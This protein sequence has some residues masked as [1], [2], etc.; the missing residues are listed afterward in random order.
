[1]REDQ[2][3]CDRRYLTGVAVMT[4][5]LRRGIIDEADYSALETEIALKYLPLFRH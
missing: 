4:D 5:M 3:V 1:M 2:A